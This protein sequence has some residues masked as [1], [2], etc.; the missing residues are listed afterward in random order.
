MI[1]Y[2][3]KE[4]IV[5]TKVGDEIGML[6]IE[7]GEYFMID[8][9]GADIWQIIESEM[10]ISDIVDK[11]ELEYNVDRDM[12]EKDTREFLDILVSKGLV[13]SKNTNL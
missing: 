13:N 3:A 2:K 5:A 11:L 12:C 7:S 4:D 10:T 6:D 9:I 8:S 1:K